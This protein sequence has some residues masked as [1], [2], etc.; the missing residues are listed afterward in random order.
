MIGV[1]Q[2]RGHENF[3]AR[4]SSPGK[5]RLQGLAYLALIPISLRAI[6]ES[7]SG[8]QSVS[9]R[10]FRQSRVGNKGAKAER[11]HT[12]ASVVE[13]NS[14]EPKIGRFSHGN[15]SASF[16]SCAAAG[17]LADSVYRCLASIPCRGLFFEWMHSTP[18][19]SPPVASAA[20]R[21]LETGFQ[22]QQAQADSAS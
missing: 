22:V 7:K 8:V 20:D 12:A 9:S 13:R 21:E 10:R 14:R 11:G 19:G 3:F 16:V 18:S 2:L 6:E 5:A 4:D 15:A 17:L 1:P